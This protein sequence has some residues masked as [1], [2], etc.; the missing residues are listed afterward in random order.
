MGQRRDVAHGSAARK[1]RPGRVLGLLPGQLA[2]HA[3]VPEGVA[4]ALREAGLRVIG[5]HT[6]GFP[7]ARDADE[8]ARAP[9][10]GSRSRG[11]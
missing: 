11:R 1:G 9:S 10:S 7:P 5:V 2:A 6:G 4:R 8:R 3:A